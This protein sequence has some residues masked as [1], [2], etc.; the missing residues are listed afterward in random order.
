MKPDYLLQA[1][2]LEDGLWREV[3]RLTDRFEMTDP[4]RV[5]LVDLRRSEMLEAT[6]RWEAAERDMREA[7]ALWHSGAVPVSVTGKVLAEI[8]S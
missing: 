8:V 5:D 2:E 7:F 6:R 1:I 3:I 4:S